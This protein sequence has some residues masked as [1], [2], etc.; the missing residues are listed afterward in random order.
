[1]GVGRGS[2]RSRAWSRSTTLPQGP[3]AQIALVGKGITFDTG[4][5][6]L[7]PAGGMGDMKSD[8]AG[9]AAVLAAIV[10]PSPAWAC[11]SR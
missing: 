8:M 10:A 1:M 6:S 7:K 3:T 4:G 11:R 2:A 5:I 9:A